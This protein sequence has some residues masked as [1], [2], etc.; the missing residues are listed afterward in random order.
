LTIGSLQKRRHYINLFSGNEKGLDFFFN[1]Y[2]YPLVLYSNS[3]TN[4]YSVAQEITSEAFVKLWKAKEIIE[5]WRKVKFLLYRI[6]YNASIE[7]IREQKTLKQNIK[8]WEYQ[9]KQS[10]IPVMHK[11][12]EAETY[13]LL[14]LLLQNLPP[15]ARQIFIM[16]Y[17]QKKGIKDIAKELGISINTVKTQKQRAI[18]NLREYQNSLHFLML[19]SLIV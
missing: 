17:F 2:Y 1:H 10:E 18:K 4:T 13:N 14:H 6:V 8:E 9:T 7:F 19:Y 15:R 5:E 3:L 12:I 11:I 16:F